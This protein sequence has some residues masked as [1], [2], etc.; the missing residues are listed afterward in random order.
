MMS[1][2]VRKDQIAA[3]LRNLVTAYSKAMAHL[4]DA[5]AVLCKELELGEIEMFDKRLLTLRDPTHAPEDAD[6]PIADQPLLSVRWHGKSCFLGN[7]MPFWFF[8]RLARRPNQYYSY[9]Q[10]LD[11]VWEGSRT[12]SAIRSV[13]KVLRRKLVA[14]GMADLADAIDGSVSRHYGLMLDKSK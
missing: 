13:V 6:R 14:A 3:S 9:E 7:T 1:T 5:L 4:E 8:E 10:L 2:K 11:E 12:F